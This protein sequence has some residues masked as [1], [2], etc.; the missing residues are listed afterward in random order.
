MAEILS[1]KERI[2][3]LFVLII[4]D[5]DDVNRVFRWD[6]RG[7]RDPDTGLAVDAEGQRIADTHLD[8]VIVAGDE[9]A[10]EGGEGAGGTTIKR[11]PVE[12]RIKILLD[13]ADD[14]GD[15]QVHNRWLHRLESAVMANPLMVEPTDVG[16]EERLATDTRTT[17]TQQI[18]TEDGQRE[19]YTIIAFEVQY[20]HDRDNPATGAGITAYTEV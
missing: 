16:N 8:V 2:E 14:E 11:M 1:I 9:V 10:D 18:L 19:C 3:R 20:E 4:Q 13:E 7:P 5:V 17:G 12:V 6:G 15:S